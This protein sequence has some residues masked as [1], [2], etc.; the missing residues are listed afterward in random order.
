MAKVAVALSAASVKPGARHQ[1]PDSSRAWYL[2]L[3]CTVYG[4][5]G[6]AGIGSTPVLY[7]GLLE[8]SGAS[9]EYA[10]LPFTA[11]MCAYFVGSLLYGVL[12]RWLSEKTLLVAASLVT[13]LSLFAS[14]FIH[15][16]AVLTAV[17]GV[18]H[19]IGVA[20][21]GV[22]PGILLSQYFVKYRA[23]AFGLMSLILSLTGVAFPP[24]A[25]WLLNEYGF[26]ATLLVLGA[27]SLHQLA[28]CLPLETWAPKVHPSPN[29]PKIGEAER[30]VTVTT[31]ID[32]KVS[33]SHGDVQGKLRQRHGEENG[34]STARPFLRCI[35]LFVC[36][37]NAVACFAIFTYT[38]TIVDFAND[39]G[40]SHYK[41]AMLMTA[42]SV[43]WAGASLSM[44]P[45]VDSGIS[46]KETVIFSS[47]VIQSAGL[48]LM[49]LLKTSYPWLVVSGF[50]L[51][52]GQGSRGF[53]LFVLLSEKFK[54]RQTPVAFALMSVSCAVPFLARAPIIGYV[55]DTLG[56]YD[57]L[58][59]T[60]GVIEAVFA[61][62]WGLHAFCKWRKKRAKLLI[63]MPFTLQHKSSRRPK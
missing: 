42:M 49:V 9:R 50:M 10:S 30:A 3:L 54:K 11:M 41:A 23:T 55:R 5:F 40:I 24:V 43:G 4:F 28:C 17:L 16:I 35:F 21:V 27:V 36:M 31:T 60:L 6:W 25:A 56:S 8:R 45:I 18:I 13:S 57:V 59:L 12:S 38:L 34:V 37:T 14:Y 1:V 53:L 20:V 63:T 7:V 32:Q 44:A 26:A 52:W 47:F 39:N 15:D 58:M 51:G 29:P 62:C 19:G 22:L 33:D 2:G 61:L 48:L 46:S